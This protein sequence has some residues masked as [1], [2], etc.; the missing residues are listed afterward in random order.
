M[1]D[2]DDYPPFPWLPMLAAA[3]IFGVFIFH[4]LSELPI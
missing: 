3:I 4:A 1:K 2:H